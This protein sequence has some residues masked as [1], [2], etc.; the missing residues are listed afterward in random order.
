MAT[1]GSKCAWVTKN[2]D[3]KVVMLFVTPYTLRDAQRTFLQVKAL[4]RTCTL[5][6]A[7]LSFNF[8]GR[9]SNLGLQKFQM[10]VYARST[11]PYE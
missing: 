10:K 4:W 3:Q 5:S 2:A 9:E 1:L 8:L 11:R 6:I 7:I